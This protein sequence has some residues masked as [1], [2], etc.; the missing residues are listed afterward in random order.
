MKLPVTIS[1]STSMVY[2]PSY[3]LEP[4]R[5][6]KAE[7]FEWDTNHPKSLSSICVEKLSQDWA[8]SPKLDEFCAKDRE[9]FLQILDTNIPLQILV[10]NIKSDIFWKR[11]YLST[12]NDSIL[13]VEEKPWINRFMERYYA[14]I[15]GNMNPKQYDPEKVNSLVKLC[16]PYIQSLHIKNLIPSDIPVQRTTSPEM[17]NLLTSRRQNGL[18]TSGGPEVLN[19][20]HISLHAA[21]GSLN[22]LTELNITYQLT[23]I[24]EEYRRDQFQFTN[25]DA[26]N[27]AHGLEKCIHLKILRYNF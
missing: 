13:M 2:K 20:D 15:L 24:G 3:I 22:N 10:D 17:E 23:N 8:G 6:L 1:S 14:D 21:L 9:L 7:N 26:R 4:E 16:G 25:N 12:W 18:K 27:L 5:Q 19:R 11:C